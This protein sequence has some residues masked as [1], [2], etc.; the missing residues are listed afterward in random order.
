ML[1]RNG[2]IRGR[3][4]DA[5][6]GTGENAIFFSKFGT[7][8]WGIDSAPLAIEK[9]KRKEKERGAGVRFLVADALHLV[10]LRTRFDTVTD[11]G[12]FHTFS[13]GERTRFSKSLRSA[14]VE[15]G[16]Y[17]ML[18]FST[19]E[20]AVWGGPRRLS[21]EEIRG[22]FGRGWTVNY[23]RESVIETKFHDMAGKA[24]LSSISVG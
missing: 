9:A 6:C 11:C 24:L 14:L 8:V 2:E 17:F 13:D 22:V 4:L 5:G 21:E 19:K 12:L 15:H 3:V 7:E 10:R 18:A 16:S 20:P 23:I 1:A